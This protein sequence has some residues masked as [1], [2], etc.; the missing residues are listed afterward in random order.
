MEETRKRGNKIKVFKMFERFDCWV[1][2]NFFTL[3]N[4]DEERYYTWDH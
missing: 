1:N 3:V 2:Q 4:E